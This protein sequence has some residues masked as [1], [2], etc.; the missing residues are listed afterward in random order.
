MRNA[1]TK[2]I[3]ALGRYAVLPAVVVALAALLVWLIALD[4]YPWLALA[5]SPIVLPAAT[6]AIVLALGLLLLPGRRNADPAVEEAAAP[7]LWAMWNELDP[8]SAGSR[9]ALVIDADMN[10]SI[11]EQR[12]FMGLFSRQLTM[13]IGLPLL[14]VLDERAV[15]AV[16]AHAALRHTSGAA[17]L[18]EFLAAAGNIFEY[19]DPET[20]ITGRIADV[21][22]NALLEWLHKEYLIL[23]RQNELAADRQAAECVGFHDAVRALVLVAGMTARIGELVF[24]PLEKELLGAIRAPVPPLQRII[25]Q[26][27]TIRTPDEIKAA[28]LARMASEK[29]DVNSTHPSLRQRLANLGFAEIPEFDAAQ[30]SALDALLSS[31]AIKELVA[32]LDNQ[33]SKN[34]TEQ[35]DIYQ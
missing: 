35:V 27:D 19:A 5:T 20:T 31:H 8:T 29:D 14:I 1:I 4:H 32:R 7:G 2:L 22:L 28:A 25:S 21:L 10:A 6:G 18:N 23:S 26:L 16:I 12:Q 30:T 13:T 24:T 3:L 34:A 15:R 11:G 9:R 33:W 17:N